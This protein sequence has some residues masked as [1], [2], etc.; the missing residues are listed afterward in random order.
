ME[1]LMTE[2]KHS[3]R[4][5]LKNWMRQTRV[6]A[7]HDVIAWGLQNFYNRAIQTKGDLVREG[8]L[9]H[10]DDT[11]KKLRGFNCK[12]EVYECNEY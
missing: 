1:A 6:F 2:V 10:L 7:T 5:M 8:F 4:D 11:E 9:R 3:K 12:D